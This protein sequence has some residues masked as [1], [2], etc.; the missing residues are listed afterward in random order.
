MNDIIMKIL[1]FGTVCELEKYET[2]LQ[3]CRKKPT[4]A[5]VVFES[6]ILKGF[7]ENGIEMEICSFPMISTFPN[8]RKLFFGGHSEILSSGY[9]CYWL[10]TINI[11]ILKQWS[12]R[13]DARKA[14]KKWA[15]S[16]GTDD[17]IMAYSI[18]PFLVKDIIRYGKKYGVKTVAIVPD[19]PENMYINQK[20][21]LKTLI[22]KQ[23]LRSSLKYQG[24]FD[25]Y[26]YLT[27]AMRDKVAPQKPYM[28]M[29]GISDQQFNITSTLKA[30][31]RVIMYAG[32]LYEKYGIMNLI[33]AFEQLENTDVELW[34]FGNGSSV[35]DIQKRS[36]SN[37]RIKYFG[38][39]SRDEILIHEREATLLINPRG[40]KED[41]TKYSFPSKTIEYMYSG[42]PLIT[43]KLEGIPK[44]YYDYVF[45]TTDNDPVL[46][47]KALEDALSLSDEQL[48]QMGQRARCFIVN[49]KNAK[50]QTGHIID[51]LTNLLG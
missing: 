2:I 36:A 22:K 48:A 35:I 21:S 34:L 49:Q 31:P 45:L 37:K 39:V 46:L 19:L 5:T 20:N 25:G 11:P 10:K 33:E 51:F 44:E 24:L 9:T 13:L 23:Y 4:V 1:Y 18:P 47:R 50:V 29:E 12:R 3:Q 14:I 40:V 15:K 26:I 32:G 6:A 27:E 7:A 16:C 30:S 38:R 43:T 17:V 8:Y 28:V 42:T 41:F